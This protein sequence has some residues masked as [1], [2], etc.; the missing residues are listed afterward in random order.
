MY[1][2]DL[3]YTSEHEWVRSPGEADSSVRVGITGT[4]LKKCIPTNRERRPSPTAAARRSMAIEL[5]LDAK[6]VSAGASPSSAVHSFV[7]T[8]T[9]S[10]TASTTRYASATRPCSAVASMRPS[11][12]SRSPAD[13]L[14]FAC[15]AANQAVYDWA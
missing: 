5:V 14:P 8:A 2:E 3:K 11:V 1:P 15:C 10:N 9:S 12:A 4:G 6:I 13:S 7:L